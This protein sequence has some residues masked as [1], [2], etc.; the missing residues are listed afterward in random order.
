MGQIVLMSLINWH[1][2]FIK[3]AKVHHQTR[4]ALL[5]EGRLYKGF[6]HLLNAINMFHSLWETA[7]LYN[8]NREKKKKKNHVSH[9]DSNVEFFPSQCFITVSENFSVL[10]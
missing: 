7:M 6:H 4:G 3:R 5:L 10:H 2:R 9:S 1:F 8:Q